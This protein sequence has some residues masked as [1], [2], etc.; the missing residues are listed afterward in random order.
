MKIYYLKYCKKNDKN[1]QNLIINYFLK[2]IK[3]INIKIIII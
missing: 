2:F 3:I 1:F